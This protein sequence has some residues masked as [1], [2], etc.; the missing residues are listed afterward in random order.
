LAVAALVINR[1]RERIITIG[2]CIVIESVRSA[3]YT[4]SIEGNKITRIL[5]ENAHLLIGF[6]ESS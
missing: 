2:A 5:L 6:G 3:A 4:A 1:E